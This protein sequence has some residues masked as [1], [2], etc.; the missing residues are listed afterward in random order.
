ML[1]ADL[2]RECASAY[3]AEDVPERCAIYI[4]GFLDGAVAT[5]ARVAENV[6]EEAERRETLT[7]RAIRT[8]VGERMQR[9]GPSVYADYCIG[10]PVPVQEVIRLVRQQF[11]SRPPAADDRARDV[12]YAVL[13]TNFPCRE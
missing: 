6:A 4:A 5:D 2:A 10:E 9:M 7:E 13:R 11:A 12:V 1:A 8:R 3:S